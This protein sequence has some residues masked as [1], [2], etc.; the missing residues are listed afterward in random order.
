MEAL[1]GQ[2][3]MGGA[4][5]MQVASATPSP[6]YIPPQQVMQ[7]SMP[8]PMMESG[9]E[10]KSSNRF[11]DYFSDINIVDVGIS[12]FIVAAVLYSINYHRFMM[13]LEKTGYADLSTRL[14]KLESSFA[15]AKKSAQVNASGSMKT[16]KKRRPMASF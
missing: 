11:K 6:N 3:A 4:N 14:S 8:Q 10:V 15:A 16:M 5:T 2:L 12:A 9:G 1:S 7:Q 13:M